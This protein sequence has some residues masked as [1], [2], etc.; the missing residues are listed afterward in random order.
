MEEMTLNFNNGTCS[1]VLKKNRNVYDVN[2]GSGEW[3]LGETTMGGPYLI[4]AIGH[5]VGLP[6][7]KIAGSYFLDNEKLELT[8]RYIESP[9]TEKF[10]CT[11]NNNEINVD[12]FYSNRSGQPVTSIKGIS[13]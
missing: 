9:H 7:L 3:S 13:K 10:V 8:L 4:P 1:M 5:Y 6:A 11:I 2:F 12:V